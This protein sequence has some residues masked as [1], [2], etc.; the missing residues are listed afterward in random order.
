MEEQHLLTCWLAHTLLYHSY[1]AQDI[2]PGDDATHSE[3]GTLSSNNNYDNP[4]QANLIYII[5]HLRLSF[6]MTL[7]WIKLT[8]KAN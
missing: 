2:C 6:Q 1:I 5:S 8:S 7:G 3:L 4:P